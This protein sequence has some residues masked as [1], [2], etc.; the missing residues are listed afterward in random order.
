LAVERPPVNEELA[1]D[2]LYGERFSPAE[3]ETKFRVWRTLCRHFF[4]RY[5][6]P[7]DTV[8]DLGAGACEFINNI[9]CHR[10]IAVDLNPEVRSY[11]A[12]GVEVHVGSCTDLSTIE[13]ATVNAV[14]ASNFFEHLPDTVTLMKTLAETRRV[15]KS[16]GQ[17]LI[18]QPN[19]AVLGGRYWDFLDH[20]LPLTEKTLSD[21]L[22]TLDFRVVE[23]R[24]RFLPYT[25][26]S[27]LPAHPFLVRLYLLVPLAHR[28][29]GGQA[30]VV[31]EKPG[32]SMLT[33]R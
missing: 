27:R 2:K 28:F 3:L 6:A 16:G 7:T 15:L 22:R 14:F 32:D 13:D 29:L 9:V 17:I 8:L 19:I 25:S 30:W 33:C 20:H 18:L 12:D 11:A 21:A 24:A 10:R 4:Q 5:I 23:A 26:K 1:I 31:G